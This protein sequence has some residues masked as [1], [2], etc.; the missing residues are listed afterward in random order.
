M[1]ICFQGTEK[2]LT[3]KPVLT[4]PQLDKPSIVEVDASDYAAD[5][6]LLQNSD[7]GLLQP[8]AYFSTAFKGSKRQR[9]PIA[10][11]AFALVVAV[12]HWHVYLA[13]TELILNTNHNPLVHLRKQKDPRGKFG[14][15]ISELEE[16]EFTVKYIRGK[17]SR[18]I[19]SLDINAQTPINRYPHSRTRSMLHSRGY[20]KFLDRLGQQ[21]STDPVIN[22]A[23]RRFAAGEVILQGRI[24][25]IQNQL[26]IEDDVLTKLGRPIVPAS[27]RTIVLTEIHKQSILGQTKRILSLKS[28]SFGRKCADLSKVS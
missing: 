28:V 5:G 24:K 4:F 2:R 27:L 12:R 9:A 15:W 16:Y 20:I 10:K 7:D 14:R 1:L 19:S 21:Q 26:R 17:V 25:R 13:G 8:V 11:E 6:V 23:K 18:P 22:R 3:S